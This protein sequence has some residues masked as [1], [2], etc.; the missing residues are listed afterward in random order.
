VP[1]G[2]EKNDSPGAK[3]RASAASDAG[4]VIHFPCSGCFVEAYGFHGTDILAKRIGALFADNGFMDEVFPEGKN[5]E[6]S[7]S[8][9]ISTANMLRTD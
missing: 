4:V 6:N 1:V 5:T 9:I 8:G 7:T 3:F 2:I